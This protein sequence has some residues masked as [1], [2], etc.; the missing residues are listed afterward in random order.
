MDAL[1]GRSLPAIMYAPSRRDVEGSQAGRFNMQA[2]ETVGVSVASF[3]ERPLM[4]DAV[5][6]INNDGVAI[7][8][9]CVSSAR[10]RSVGDGGRGFTESRWVEIPVIGSNG[11]VSG[12]LCHTNSGVDTRGA[13]AAGVPK[14]RSAIEDVAHFVVHDINNLFAVIGSGLLRLERENDAAHRQAIVGKLEDAIM[15]GAA[16]GRQLL[17]SARS[18]SQSIDG[19]VT[20]ARLKAIVGAL[21]LA[22]R[23]DISVRAEIAPDLWAFNSDAEELYFALL[24]LCQNSADAM[25]D[26]GVITVAARNIEQLSAAVQGGVEIVVADH[27]KGMAEDILSRALIPSFTTKLSGSGNGL[28]EVQRFVEGQNGSLRIVSKPGIGTLV[29]LF[30][31]CV[32]AS[33]ISSS[34]SAGR[35]IAYLASPEGGIFHLVNPE[36]AAPPP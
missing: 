11:E 30:L 1:Y 6:L 33:Q 4:E 21:E 23:S 26:G 10:V 15:R 17:D 35:E 22:L 8:V 9:G 29:H 27:G 13:V 16:L 2:E 7:G 24:N 14:R 12:I 28:T 5:M 18:G 19:F 3:S 32:E 36:A 34:S 20:G 31:P 25:P